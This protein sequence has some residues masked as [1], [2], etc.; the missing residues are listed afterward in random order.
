[1]MLLSMIQQFAEEVLKTINHELLQW[2][3]NFNVF[4]KLSRILKRR[5]NIFEG[6]GKID[7]AHAES[8]AFG[9]ILKDGTP[10]R[11]TGQDS[12]RGTFA[13]RNL[14]FT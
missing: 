5:E 2:P 13:H 3:E 12:Q 14:S 11:L 9:S 7:W 10:I 6:E 1:M 4:Q 8:L